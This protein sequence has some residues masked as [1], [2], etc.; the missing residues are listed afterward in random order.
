MKLIT[1]PTQ[2]PIIKGGL[3]PHDYERSRDPWHRDAFPDEFKDNA[4]EQAYPRKEGWMGIDYWGNPLIFV[5]DGTEIE[6]P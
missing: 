5:P 4:P 6:V 2:K 3:E 1:S